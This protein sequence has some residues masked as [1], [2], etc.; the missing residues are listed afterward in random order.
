MAGPSPSAVVEPLSKPVQELTL[1]GDELPQRYVYKGGDGVIDASFPQLEVPVIDVGYLISSS[2]ISGEE[3]E[4]LQSALSTRDC[5]Q[6][7]SNG[8][9]KSPVCRVVTNSE[10]EKVTLAVFCIPESEKEIEPV[11]ELINEKRPRLYKKLKIYV[12]IYFQNYQ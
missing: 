4:K 3:L 12:D 8:M 2:N 5:F 11:E 7:M 9:F 10:R 1:D 6:I